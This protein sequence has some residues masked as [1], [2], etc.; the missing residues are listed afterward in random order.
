MIGTEAGPERA[1]CNNESA[2]NRRSAHKLPTLSRHCLFSV[3][4]DQLDK[5]DAL[6]IPRCT[7]IYLA[8]YASFLASLSF[9]LT[10]DLSDSI[11]GNV[12]GRLQTLDRAAV[13]QPR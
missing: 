13:A 1:N 10:T 8:C 4:I 9:L 6:L 12:L 5:A 2:I 3:S 11:F 7:C